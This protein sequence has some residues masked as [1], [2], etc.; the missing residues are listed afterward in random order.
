M[1]AGPEAGIIWAMDADAV[2]RAGRRQA[3][4]A[5]HGLARRYGDA[6]RA[7]EAAAA[8]KVVEDALAV[9]LTPAEVHALVIQPAMIRIGDLWEVN[10]ITVAEEHLATAISQGVLIKLLE[11]LAVAPPRSRE[12][13]LLAAVEGQAHVLGLRMIADVLEG[14]GF[15][16]LYLGPSVP[17]D[18]LSGFAADRQPA[19]TGLAFEMSIGVGALAESILAVH[20][21]CPE[22]R[23]M[24][25]GRAVPQGFVSAGYPRVANS[26]EVLSV[27]ERLLSEP[28][29]AA[30][31]ILDLLRPRGPHRPFAP[32]DLFES[33]I[34][35]ERLAG[36]A[37]EATETAREYIR[38]A[39]ALKYL[40][41]RDPVTDLG[42]RRAF[43]DRMYEHIHA[44]GDDAAG[45]LLMIDIDGF[46]QIND[47]HGHEAGD[48]V[49]RVI[50]TALT[51][52][53]R[54]QDFAARAGSDEFA[55][56]L[57]SASLEEAHAITDR[58]REAIAETTEPRAT[59]SIGLAP[60]SPDARAVVLAAD[61]ALHRAKIAG[62]D[63]CGRC[64]TLDN[65]FQNR[66]AIVRERSSKRGG[67]LLPDFIFLPRSIS[68]YSAGAGEPVRA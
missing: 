60:L 61:L 30:P 15:D 51:S 13:V 6:L 43:D 44:A 3:D 2:P 45:A 16:V 20:E 62:R 18:A 47:T 41:F 46:K 34:L 68:S 54:E 12:R 56:L 9:G 19:I 66:A 52:A 64:I 50:G 55:V 53:I 7:A 39:G 10:A 5:A 49:L 63:R 31:R 58:I 27:V 1:V 37:E 14:A 67:A 21:A 23:I 25:G 48:R 28:V 11:P 65:D 36:V 24:L 40:A 57:P 17:A 59:V 4:A 42:N 26:V 38:R 33:N 29:H 35:A 22:T 32:T 8:E